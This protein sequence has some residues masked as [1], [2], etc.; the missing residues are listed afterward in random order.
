MEKKEEMYAE[1][2]NNLIRATVDGQLSWEETGSG[3]VSKDADWT[4]R[5]MAGIGY[6]LWHR[7]NKVGCN[8]FNGIGNFVE[9]TLAAKTATTALEASRK[10]LRCQ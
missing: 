9:T 8:D 6:Q 2:E 1:I 3:F 5:N 10:Q 4:L 7:G